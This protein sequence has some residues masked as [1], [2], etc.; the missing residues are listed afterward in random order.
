MVHETALARELVLDALLLAVWR[1]KP[2][3]RFIVHSDHCSQGDIRDRS[4]VSE[5]HTEKTE[6][7]RSVR[8]ITELC[9][10]ATASRRWP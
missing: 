4:S 8:P 3:N 6:V 7:G 10:T 1:R 5:V 9:D 2:T